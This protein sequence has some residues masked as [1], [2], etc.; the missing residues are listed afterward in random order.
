MALRIKRR[1]FSSRLALVAGTALD[2]I[3]AIWMWVTRT[4]PKELGR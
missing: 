4:Q 3:F 1:W 2:A